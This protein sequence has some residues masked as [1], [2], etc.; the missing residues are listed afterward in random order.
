MTGYAFGDWYTDTALTADFDFSTPITAN[1][2][3]YAKWTYNASL[4]VG[5]EDPGGGIIFYRPGTSFTMTDT[6]EHCYYLE[7]APADQGQLPWSPDCP[8]GIG[9]DG[10]AIG[11]GRKNT[12]MIIAACP[13]NTAANNAAKACAAYSNNGKTDW[14][15]PSQNEIIELY[16]ESTTVGG[17]I[18]DFY[19]TSLQ[20]SGGDAYLYGFNGRGGI[21]ETRNQ[22]HFYVRAIRSF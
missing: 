12:A 14:F 6:G 8:D 17:F 18:T 22:P 9:A 16:K 10:T 1:I 4:N 5:E 21:W 13:G 2:M 15:L 20:G 3:L 19:W 11:A 7:A